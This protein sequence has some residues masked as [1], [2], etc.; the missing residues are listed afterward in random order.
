[1]ADVGLTNAIRELTSAMRSQMGLPAAGGGA[2][3]F[4]GGPRM[5]DIGDVP[6]EWHD[7]IKRLTD[8]LDEHGDII[9]DHGKD[10]NLTKG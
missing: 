4:A 9:K 5:A 6:R 2:H 10:F 8:G 1:M 3:P 7:D